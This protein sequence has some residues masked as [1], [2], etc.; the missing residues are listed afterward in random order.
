MINLGLGVFSCFD[1]HSFHSFA[2][3]LGTVKSFSGPFEAFQK[4]SIE[5]IFG[6]QRFWLEW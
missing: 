4:F 1:L 6:L 2:R 3:G 5:E